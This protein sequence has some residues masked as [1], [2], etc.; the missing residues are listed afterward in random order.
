MKCVKENAGMSVSSAN[1]SMLQMPERRLEQLCRERLCTAPS[2][3]MSDA[4]GESKVL[5]VRWIDR[6]SCSGNCRLVDGGF[7]RR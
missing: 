2:I 7:L 6:D 4:G 1:D 3:V 5:R